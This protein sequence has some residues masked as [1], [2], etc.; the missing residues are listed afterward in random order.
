[1]FLIW[2]KHYLYTYILI[3]KSTLLFFVHL[4]QPERELK[5]RF[6]RIT[7]IIFQKFSIEQMYIVRTCRQK[8]NFEKII[9]ARNKILRVHLITF[10]KFNYIVKYICLIYSYRQ[11]KN[12]LNCIWMSTIAKKRVEILQFWHYA[13]YFWKI[14]DRTVVNNRYTLFALVVEEIFSKK[15]LTLEIKFYAYI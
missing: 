12:S 2:G 14:P 5:Y 11:Q 1:M 7:S 4:R 13:H 3:K 8:K 6:F 15:L 9:N 10:Y